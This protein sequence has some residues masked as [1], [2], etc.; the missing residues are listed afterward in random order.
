MG[1]QCVPPAA[2]HIYLPAGQPSTA[3]PT[4]PVAE[5]EADPF[6]TRP[7]LTVKGNTSR[8]HHNELTFA[9]W[10]LPI[11]AGSG[12]KSE[13]YRLGHCLLAADGKIHPLQRVK[14]I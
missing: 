14:K 8:R 6:V 10:I 3:G 11:S 12:A 2:Q 5:N 13:T 1:W 4:V 9:V 7:G